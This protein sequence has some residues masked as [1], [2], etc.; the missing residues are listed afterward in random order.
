MPTLPNLIF[1]I[2]SVVYL[3]LGALCNESPSAAFCQPEWFE[4]RRRRKSLFINL[5]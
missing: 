1:V 4:F 5:F 3:D 2:I